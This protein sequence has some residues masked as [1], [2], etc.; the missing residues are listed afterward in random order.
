LTGSEGTG[1]AV[2]GKTMKGPTWKN[3]GLNSIE[4]KGMGDDGNSNS[5]VEQSI[6]F[7]II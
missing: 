6:C 4:C 2:S 3:A 5:A 1:N 7:L